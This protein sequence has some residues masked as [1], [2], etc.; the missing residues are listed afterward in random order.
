M[1]TI[2]RQPQQDPPL[3]RSLARPG[4]QGERSALPRRAHAV[5][6]TLAM[7][8]VASFWSGTV[9]VEV[10]GSPAQVAWLKQA[11]LYALLVLVPCM[12]ATGASG[13]FLARHWRHRTV[14]LKRRRM[15]LVGAN[16]LLCML[17]LAWVLAERSAQGLLDGPFYALQAA[18][19]LAGAVQLALL[20]LNWRDGYRLRR[21]VFTAP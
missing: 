10:W 5:A 9:L 15:A 3:P 19:L 2:T 4:G 12:A 16:G 11:I 1:N 14:A 17:P 6:G 13:M 21:P 7:A 8:L 20:G 18:E